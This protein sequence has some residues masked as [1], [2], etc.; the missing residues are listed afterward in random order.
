VG[1]AHVS[2][3]HGNFILADKGAKAADVLEL[4]RQI[5]ERVKDLHGVSLELEIVVW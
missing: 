1:G 4:I 2:E 3:K 5:R